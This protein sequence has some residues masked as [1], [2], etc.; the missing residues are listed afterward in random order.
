MALVCEPAACFP[1]ALGRAL[2]RAAFAPTAGQIALTLKS[3]QSAEKSLWVLA[4]MDGIFHRTTAEIETSL[5][6]LA[7]ID[8]GEY[9]WHPRGIEFDGRQGPEA[10]VWNGRLTVIATLQKLDP[11][12][13]S[14]CAPLWP[15]CQNTFI[16]VRFGDERNRQRMSAELL[17]KWRDYRPGKTSTRLKGSTDGADSY[18]TQTL[19]LLITNL[20]DYDFRDRRHVAAVPPGFFAPLTFLADVVATLRGPGFD[21]ETLLSRTNRFAIFHASMMGKQELD[22]EDQ[23]IARK[24]LLDAVPPAALEVLR[25]IPLD[26]LWTAD[27]IRK[28]CRQTLQKIQPLLHSLSSAGCLRL[29]EGETRDARRPK[30]KLDQEWWETT[31][32]GQFLLTGLSR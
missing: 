13:R 5:R 8:R 24:V 25:V 9:E 1:Q 26:G 15:I 30:K 16:N 12:Q 31:P 10:F 4:G 11:L 6:Q 18:V 14:R 19:G 22:A 2:G 28:A 7:E 3:Q 32:E 23:A 21:A 17:D 29:S 20:M 27:Q